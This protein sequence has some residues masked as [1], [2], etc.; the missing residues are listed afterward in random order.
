MNK[1]IWFQ[2]N[3]HVISLDTFKGFTSSLNNKSTFTTYGIIRLRCL[4]LITLEI[5]Q[6]V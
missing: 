6:L 3:K 4:I 2:E 1:D 5:F